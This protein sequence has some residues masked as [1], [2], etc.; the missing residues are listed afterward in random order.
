MHGPMKALATSKSGKRGRKKRRS[1]AQL[2]SQGA[3]AV[4]SYGWNDLTDAER[5][6]WDVRAKTT[7]CRSRRGR[8]RYL[9]GQKYYVKVNA[10]R[11]FLGLPL[12]R[13]PPE[14]VTFGPNPVGP[15]RITRLRG[16]LALKLSVPSAHAA[17]IRVLASPPRN[18]GRRFCAD[19]R[20]LCPLPAP[21]GG[22]SDITKEYIKKF[23]IPRAGMRIFIQTRQ[24]VDGQQDL[25]VQ[26]DAIVP[27]HHWSLRS[28]AVAD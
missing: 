25:P 26:T 1:A 24:Q 19:F 2:R 10:A 3:L 11:V 15:F 13:L 16:V 17:C 9:S 28:S 22:E 7:L 21:R 12:L 5:R 8:S 14:S 18:A 23:G 4:A 6:V 27:G 20:Y